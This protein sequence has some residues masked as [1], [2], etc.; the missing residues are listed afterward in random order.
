MKCKNCNESC[1]KKGFQNNVQRL[2]CKACK[3]YQ[4][5]NYKNKLIDEK[6]QNLIFELL[7]ESVSIRGLARVLK[8]SPSTIQRWIL[9]LSKLVQIPLY[10]EF[11]QEYEVDEM[12][13]Y[14]NKNC[15]ENWIWITYAIN[16]SNKNIM[17]LVVGARTKNTIRPVTETLLDLYPKKIYTDKCN[18][19]R[20]LIPQKLH[21]TKR[22]KTNNIERM[23]LTIRNRI[24]R[25]SR[26]TLSYSKSKI[27]LEATM[28]LFFQRINWTFCM[29]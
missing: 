15:G 24:K 20:S 17:G 6:D 7:S 29:K 8:C 11:G 14:L 21:S 9:K 18:V 3:K 13:T 16:K 27:M 12:C 4:L 28:I 5:V 19:Y 22:Y 26:K 23:N 25:L 2:F 10:G 1:I